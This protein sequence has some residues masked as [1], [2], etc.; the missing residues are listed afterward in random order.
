MTIAANVISALPLAAQ[1]EATA[2]ST[3]KPP[4]RRKITARADAVL[5]P[6]AR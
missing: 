3:G 5:Q 6:E 1:P 2:A 4:R